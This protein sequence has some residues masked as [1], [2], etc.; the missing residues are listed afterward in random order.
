LFLQFRSNNAVTKHNIKF[1][2]AK[3][4]LFAIKSNSLEQCSQPK[5]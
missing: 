4:D 5:K 2:V 3:C 1:N